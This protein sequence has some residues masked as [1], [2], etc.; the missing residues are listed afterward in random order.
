M[1]QHLS[2]SDTSFNLNKARHEVRQLGI[3][4]LS[5]ESK[6]D[7]ILNKLI[8]LGAKVC[9]MLKFFA[10]CITQVIKYVYYVQLLKYNIDV[11]NLVK[12]SNTYVSMVY[13]M[14]L[15]DYVIAN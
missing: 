5:N 7:A 12:K 2:T 6:E 14:L 11:S 10:N 9:F 1:K 13:F 3:K 4:G 15:F 8:Q